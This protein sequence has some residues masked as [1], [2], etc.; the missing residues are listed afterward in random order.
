M[1]L[2]LGTVVQF[3]VDLGGLS[4]FLVY[5]VFVSV[6]WQAKERSQELKKQVGNIYMNDPIADF[7]IRIKN[8]KRFTEI[9]MKKE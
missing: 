7:L 5:A 9:L 2:G 4:D 1:K 3:V 8:H 6:D